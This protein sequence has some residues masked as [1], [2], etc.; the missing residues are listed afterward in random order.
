MEEKTVNCMLL[1]DAYVGKT[2]ML[3]SYTTD[4]FSHTYYPTL[5]EHYVSEVKI[6]DETIKLNIWYL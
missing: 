1:G 6:N 2:C 4:C 3:I 5:F